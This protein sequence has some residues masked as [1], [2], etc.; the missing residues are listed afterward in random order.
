MSSETTKSIVAAWEKHCQL[1][2]NFIKA[3]QEEA[4]SAK[5]LRKGRSVGAIIAHMH[6]NRLD[7]L[8]PGAPELHEDL[9]KIQRGQT[10]DLDFLLTNLE[11]SG[12]AVSQWLTDSLD[13]GGKVKV[14]GGQAASLMGYLIAHESYHHG[15]IGLILGHSGFA[16]DNNEAYALWNWK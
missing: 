14:L 5:L 16:L 3:I 13:E 12:T 15:E 9:S 1:N 4:L 11:Q 7:W 2:Q 6:N 8:K 10:K